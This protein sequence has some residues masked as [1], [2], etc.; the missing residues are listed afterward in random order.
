MSLKHESVYT[1]LFRD[2]EA[3]VV[4][5]LGEHVQRPRPPL[6]SNATRSLHMKLC[7]PV[8]G[9]YIPVY[10]SIRS[11]NTSIHQY[12]VRIYQYTPAYGQYLFRDAEAVVVVALGE[13][14]QRP[15]PPRVPPYWVRACSRFVCRVSWEG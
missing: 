11:V 8:Y 4:V 2:A 5:A 12:T 15:R 7:I 14:V 13:H 1:D 3:V 6:R 10:T 9:Q